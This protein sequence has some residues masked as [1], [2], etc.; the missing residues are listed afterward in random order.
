LA[1]IPTHPHLLPG[2]RRNKKRK[3]Q[4]KTQRRKKIRVM[5]RAARRRRRLALAIEYVHKYK[6][7]DGVDETAALLLVRAEEG[8]GSVSR[9]RGA[10]AHGLVCTRSSC[11]VSRSRS[12]SAAG[13]W[14]LG[15]RE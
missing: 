14:S 7:Q 5:P 9:R 13:S 3:K 6:D 15:G 8:R 12:W 11:E 10:G 2:L 4:E 1:L